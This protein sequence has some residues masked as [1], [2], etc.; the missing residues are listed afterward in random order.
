MK[1]LEDVGLTFDDLL[2]IPRYS[3]IE[4]RFDGG[5]VLATSLFPQHGSGLSLPIVSANMDTVTEASMATAMWNAGGMGII[6]RFMSPQAHLEA[7][8]LSSGAHIICLGVGN[9]SRER[10]DYIMSNG[11]DLWIEGVLIDI[12]HGDCLAME[13]Q[14]KW[15]KDKY[16]S[17]GVIAGNVATGYGAA[18]LINAGAD[19]IKVG[20]GPGSLC[21]TR[22]K[23][24]NGVP[25]VTALCA[26]I[27]EVQYTNKVL[28]VIADGGIRNSGDIIKAL[29]LGANAVMVG[30]LVAGTEEAPGETIIRQGS[31]W[32]TY[33]GMASKEAQKSWKGYASSVEGEIT[34]VPYK[35]P[36]SDVI[37]ELKKGILSGMS[38][39]DAHNLAELHKN[40]CF[41]KQTTSGLRESQAH[42]L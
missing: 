4:S 25:Q 23:T 10:L 1:I 22:I 20:V 2:L 15:V 34:E 36:V 24:G 27:K 28:T 31:R 40:A 13:E 12:A 17:L 21:T 5:I 39:Q 11:E 18:R 41:I 33:R 8:K 16:P 29:A 37:E 30:S 7:L 35:G 6:H 38:Y 19:C 42:G 26:V 14:I 3:T 32:K 9:S